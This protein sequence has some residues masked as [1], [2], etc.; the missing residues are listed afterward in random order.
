MSMITMDIVVTSAEKH[1]QPR[2]A[3]QGGREWVTVIQAVDSQGWAVR[4]YIIFA[5]KVHLA[6]WYRN[7]T[8]LGDWKV[9]LSHN[10]W[11]TNEIGVE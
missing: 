6:S 11:T 7:T 10:G 2:Q 8:L 5:G 3:R 1:G 4:L 9:D